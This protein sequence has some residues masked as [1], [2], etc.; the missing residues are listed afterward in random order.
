M[1][2][3]TKDLYVRCQLPDSYRWTVIGILRHSEAIKH[4]HRSLPV[5]SEGSLAAPMP[6][7]ALSEGDQAASHQGPQSV[8]KKLA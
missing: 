4:L 1:I 7:M 8:W 3:V 6:N 5:H 2:Y